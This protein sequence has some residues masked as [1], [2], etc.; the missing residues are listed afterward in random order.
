M[1][2]LTLFSYTTLFGKNLADE[3]YY[4]H[5]EQILEPAGFRMVT[6]ARGREWGVSLDKRF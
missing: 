5:G 1:R 4:L 3:E 2:V 6:P